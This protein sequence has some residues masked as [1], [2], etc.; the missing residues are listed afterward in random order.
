MIRCHIARRS[1]G[2]VDYYDGRYYDGRNH[3]RNKTQR[4]RSH[5]IFPE[6]SYVEH[7][8][9]A[10]QSIDRGGIRRA[11]QGDLRVRLRLLEDGDISVSR[12]RVS[13]DLFTIEIKCR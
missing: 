11:L 4:R 9:G 6:K 12:C 2:N 1:R 3:V 7:G 13:A 10:V 5:L 8:H